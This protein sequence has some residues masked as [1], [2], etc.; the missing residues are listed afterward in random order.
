MSSR[1]A[2]H[3]R[4]PIPPQRLQEPNPK[5]TVAANLRWGLG[6]GL[7]LA[8]G[9]SAFVGLMALFRGSTEYAQYGG[10]T[11][12][13]I[14]V[15]YY[16]AGILGDALFGL[17]RPLQTRYTGK[18]LTAY[19]LLF[20][21]YG[22]GTATFL[23]LWSKGDPHPVPLRLLLAMWAVLCLVLAPIYVQVFRNSAE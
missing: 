16:V 11:T 10:L 22:G 21:V 19:L 9:F 15:F 4:L 3:G 14:V 13:R 1:R 5:S 20:L 8:T 6:W 17:L 7:T 18:L 23:P 12:G 2:R